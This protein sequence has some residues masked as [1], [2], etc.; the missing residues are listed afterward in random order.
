MQLNFRLT[1]FVLQTL[2][3]K[4]KP[5]LITSPALPSLGIY[6][7]ISRPPHRS[8]STFQDS[9]SHRPNE[10]VSSML[11]GAPTK[12]GNKM[13][14]R[15]GQRSDAAKID[16]NRT[17]HNRATSSQRAQKINEAKVPTSVAGQ[18][19]KAGDSLPLPPTRRRRREAPPRK[20]RHSYSAMHSSKGLLL[21]SQ[22]P[23]LPS[24]LFENPVENLHDAIHADYSLM[25]EILQE[26][27]TGNRFRLT[28]TPNDGAEP[29][30]TL[31]QGQ[32][33]VRSFSR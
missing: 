10:L 11:H 19:R 2:R 5:F 16:S 3:T 26:D 18:K 31:G 13:R 6:H 29:I 24:A 23:H 17:V 4:G 28:C 32:T 15:S 7:S 27:R 25:A 8:E 14:H 22:Y 21:A 9:T 12:D 20:K 33:R 1:F 30:S